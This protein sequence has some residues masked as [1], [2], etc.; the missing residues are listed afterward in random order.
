LVDIC[1]RFEIGVKKVQP[2]PLLVL[3][4]EQFHSSG[5]E[6]AESQSASSQ[7]GESGLK[8]LRDDMLSEMS[9]AELSRLL[10]LSESTIRVY[11][12]NPERR[13]DMGDRIRC[14]PELKEKALRL[15]AEHRQEQTASSANGTEESHSE[16]SEPADKSPKRLRDDMLSE[17]SPAELSRLLGLSENTIRVYLCNPERRK[18]VGDR[19][20]SDPDL[21]ERALR[22]VAEHRKEQQES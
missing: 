16:P 12:S 9:P 7:P 5:E 13:K 22:L 17:I 8:R 18:D 15:V 1:K 11:L 6:N 4:E 19:I 21:K 14:N 20:R 3:D 10:G 2:P